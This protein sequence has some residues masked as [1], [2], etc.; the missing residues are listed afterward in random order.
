[1]TIREQ[2]ADIISGGAIT[3]AREG[4]ENGSGDTRTR[5]MP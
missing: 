2:I 1:M 5:S 3:R 4:E